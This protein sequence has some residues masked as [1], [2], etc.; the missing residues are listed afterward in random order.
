MIRSALH[1]LVLVLLVAIPF[2]S[3]S[4]SGQPAPQ[5][6]PS[7]DPLLDEEL[8][9]QPVATAI[10]TFRRAVD[11]PLLGELRAL[12]IAAGYTF[13]SLPIVIANIDAFQREALAA[14]PDVLSIYA[15]RVV[16]PHLDRSH[17]ISGV[18]AVRQ[19][20]AVRE[21]MVLRGTGTGLPVSG[22]GVGVAVVDTG[23]DATHPDLKPGRN[24]AQNV[25]F[26]AAENLLVTGAADC[27]IGL[28]NAVLGTALGIPEPVNSLTRPLRNPDLGFV[29]FPVE[30]APVSDVEGGHGTFVSGIVAGSG[31]ASGG[32]YQGVAPGAHLV[33]LTAGNDCGLPLHGIIGAFDYVL[34]HHREHNIRVVNNSWGSRLFSGGLDPA[35]PINFATCQ[36]HRAGIAVVFSAGNAGNA[37][38]AINPYST[39]PWVISVAAS[40]KKDL[41]DPATFS[42]RGVND[43][44][45]ADTAG[46]YDCMS[47]ALAPP[48]N[49]RPDLTAPGVDIKSTRSKFPGLTN[50]LG[51]APLVGND[52]ATI[53][54]AHL[55][56]YTTSQGTSFSAPH[57]SGVV[58]LMMQANPGLRPDDVVRILRETAT[59]MPYAERIVGA[60]YLDARNAVR[61]ALSLAAV[62]H[63][64]TLIPQP[65]G[66]ACT[67]PG[68]TKLT[69]ADGDSLSG[70]RGHDLKAFQLAQPLPPDGAPQQLVFR[71]LTDAGGVPSPATA[72]YVSFNAPDGQVRGVR[73]TGTSTGQPVFQSYVAGASNA[74]VRDGRFVASTRPALPSSSFDPVKGE[75]VIRV[76]VSDVGVSAPGESLV[77]FNAGV[78]ITTDPAQLGAG[79]TFVDDEMPDGLGRQSSHTVHD[80]VPCG[81]A[82]PPP[83]PPES[84][85][86]LPGVLRL[87]DASGDT[88]TGLA[89]HDLLSLHVAQQHGADGLTAYL[90]FRIRTDPGGLPNPST[91]WFVSFHAPDGEIRGVR[92][93]GTV[94]AVPVFQ[95]Y[96]VGASS[97]GVR[98]GRFVQSSAPA[99]PASTFDPVDGVITIHVRAS[100]LGISAPG[101]SLTGFNAGVTVTT[102]PFG[103]PGA[104]LI[105]DGMPGDLS[106]SGSFT[107]LDRSQCR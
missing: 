107:L 80:N 84:P 29:N 100:A 77:G 97:G 18:L 52:T 90:V 101:Q 22:Q 55:P 93:T 28:T 13:R 39:M 7:V 86:E 21:A 12:G 68:E 54:P 26:P 94:D 34:S 3:S 71:I 64:A 5:S 14:R 19:D 16:E 102:A 35:N 103:G 1:A 32:K 69:D 48:P 63:P 85:C 46:T 44:T 78:T 45:G 91:A 89:G 15:N 10:V 75:I 6:R 23:L 73:M 4:L 66:P 99:E 49:L 82:P 59:P 104:T 40:V 106:R 58:A 41:G 33:A 81:G 27:A 37:S 56:Y 65:P 2:G 9:A 47:P 17:V 96:V 20:V 105:D 70:R 72:W 83:P 36:M 30:H 51:T 76:P 57:V 67:L 92:M 88:L 50:T 61:R 87:T 74:G 8:R 24:V 62:A 11:E 53:D 38:N 95:S 60:G 43:G 79:A 25:W 42:S 31:A 98:D